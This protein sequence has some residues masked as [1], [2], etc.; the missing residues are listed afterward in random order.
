M[1]AADGAPPDTAGFH[2]TDTQT[3]SEYTAR[4][5]G[6]A[7]RYASTEWAGDRRRGIP[8]EVELRYLQ[9]NSARDGFAPK[10]NVW[11]VGLRL[12]GVIFR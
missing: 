4:S 5:L 3:G 7:A 8:V 10:E 11:Q 1:T 2:P 9:T 12:Y 6:F